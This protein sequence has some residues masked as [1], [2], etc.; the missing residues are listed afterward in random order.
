MCEGSNKDD[1]N[2]NQARDKTAVVA[3]VDHGVP[4]QR[5]DGE[6]IVANQ[7]PRRVPAHNQA[8]MGSVRVQRKI[9]RLGI[10]QQ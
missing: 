1:S 8:R 4:K 10:C 6:E 7:F 9:P 3:K 5:I 2:G